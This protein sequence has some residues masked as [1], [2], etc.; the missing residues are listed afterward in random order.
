[1]EMPRALRQILW[2]VLL[3]LGGVATLAVIAGVIR[4]FLV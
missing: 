3:W 1:M 4:L 2:F